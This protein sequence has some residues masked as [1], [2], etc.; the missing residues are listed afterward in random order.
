MKYF[1]TGASGFIGQHLVR[2]LAAGR[3]NVVHCLVRDENKLPQ[4]IRSSI[5]ICK[6]DDTALANYAKQILSSDVIFHVGGRA[7]L[8]DGD[9]YQRDN[10]EFTHALIKIAEK[11]KKLKRFVFTSTIGAVDRTKDDP[12]TA[13]LTEESTPF[14]L[15]EY[16]R[17]KLNCEVALKAST[18]PYVIVRPVL[19]FGPGMREKSHLRV[20]LDAVEKQ[21]FFARCNFPGKM[22]FIHVNDLVDALLLVSSHSKAVHQTYFA[23]DDE[24]I[25][26]GLVFSQLGSILGKRAGSFNV[27]IGVSG[28]LRRLRPYLPLRLQNLYSDVLTA[29][30]K[31]LRSLGF[32][33]KVIQ[34][35]GFRGTAHDHFKKENSG[36]GTAVITGGAG[37]IGH[38][39]SAQLFARGYSVTIVDRNKPLG[40]SV[41]ESLDAEFLYAD[42]SIEKDVRNVVDFLHAHSAKIDLLVN[43]AGIGRR[44]NTEEIPTG[45]LVDLMRI[46][47]EAP[48]RLTNAILPEFIKRG[49]GTIV[50][51]GSSSGFQPLPYMS[52]YAASKSFITHYTE[53]VQ[54]EL[55]GRGIPGS[56]EVILVSPSGTAT[57]FQ[58]SAG[59]KDEDHSRLLSPDYVASVIVRLIGRGSSV[60]IIG[61]SGKMMNIVGRILPMRVQ[62]TLWEKLM[63]SMR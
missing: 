2:R 23:A 19:V 39:L 55:A 51:I 8:G 29:S 61:L 60:H 5:T 52:A 45:E 35:E 21:K 18:L 7:D 24:P 26:L 50:T 37:G 63:R 32:T 36:R 56:V 12:C 49:R 43:N 4:D 48:V 41:A 46:N 14:P 58:K 57:N 15:T 30:N 38:A 17:S 62:V 22:S 25:S 59:V 54:G 6:G 31:K 16:G 53:A 34:R 44:G 11:S 42:L 47:C 9:A 33:P 1:V 40:K 28:I 13:S 27:S 20:F 3:G 10:I